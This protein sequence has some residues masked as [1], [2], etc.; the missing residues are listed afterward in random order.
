[1]VENI[2]E[3]KPLEMESKEMAGMFE[4]YYFILGVVNN[5]FLISIFLTV[6]FWGTSKVKVM[7]IAYL[8]LA[9]PSIYGVFIAQQLDMPAGYSIFL[10]IFTAFLLLE[11]LYEYVL[12]VPFRNNWKLL[13]PY[14]MLYW[15][16]NYGFVVMSWENSVG[17]GR[18]MLGLFI[19]Q[20]IAN[21][22]SHTKKK[23]CG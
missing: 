23:R 11:G 16:M 10:G 20:L 9:A 21:I 22:L 3:M 4:N 13:V 7:G 15:S 14:L 1:M 6:K 19:V 5:I 17:Q 2:I 12:K 18:I 8:S